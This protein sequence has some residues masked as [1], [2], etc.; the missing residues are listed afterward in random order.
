MLFQ[1]GH[2]QFEKGPDL[3]MSGKIT[4]G[5]EKVSR[6]R[7]NV[8]STHLPTNSVDCGDAKPTGIFGTAGSGT[9]NLGD[10]SDACLFHNGRG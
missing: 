6:G 1:D 10:K 9:V 4:S 5:C 2:V 3:G 7:D 8:Y